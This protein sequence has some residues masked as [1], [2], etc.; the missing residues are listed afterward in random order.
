VDLLGAPVGDRRD[1][2]IV[3][4]TIKIAEWFEGLDAHGWHI[5][6]TD[7]T[8]GGARF[9]ITNVEFVDT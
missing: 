6:V 5:R 7:G 9:E 2:R 4:V 1:E 3:V 8:G